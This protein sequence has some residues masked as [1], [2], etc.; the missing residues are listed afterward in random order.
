M[1]NAFEPL[2][3][4]TSSPAHAALQESIE[5]LQESIEDFRQCPHSP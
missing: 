2:D 3:E 1:S 5:D 4:E